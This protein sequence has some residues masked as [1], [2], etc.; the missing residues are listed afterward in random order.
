MIM[1]SLATIRCNYPGFLSTA[2]IASDRHAA[3]TPLELLRARRRVR[4]ARR[5]PGDGREER[6]V[7]PLLHLSSDVCR[8][9]EWQL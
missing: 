4:G 3:A 6:Y 5:L 9:S 2:S 1:S 8:A 7:I